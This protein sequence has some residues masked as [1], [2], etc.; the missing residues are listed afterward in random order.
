MNPGLR[1]NL[2]LIRILLGLVTGILLWLIW[3][4][5]AIT[6]PEIESIKF[7]YF[8]TE[9]LFS[10]LAHSSQAA[11]SPYTIITNWRGL[12]PLACLF[13]VLF[14]TLNPL[15]R[16][17][18]WI[19]SL[20]LAGVTAFSCFYAFQY[21]VP[22]GGPVIVLNCFYLCGTLIYLETE[23]IERN[24]NLAIDLQQQAE[25][26]RK[27][28][29]KDLHDESLQS[30]SRVIRLA[31]KLHDEL[32]ENPV[33]QEM[34]SRLESCISGM[35]SIISDLHPAQLEEFGLAAALEQLLEE[36]SLASQVKTH[37]QD[38][39]AGQRLPAFH[40][41]CIY[42]IAQ[43]AINNI[44]KHAQASQVNVRLQKTDRQ[45]CLKIGDNG[46]G[47]VRKKKDSFGLQNITYR[48]RLINGKV[49][50]K[51]PDEFPSGTMLV[52]TVPLLKPKP[53]SDTKT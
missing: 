38:T 26:E 25:A 39:S 11:A 32:P 7:R 2:S 28:I 16:F 53:E 22:W 23:K 8:L 21:I 14:S 44:E 19:L 40:E 20:V 4:A 46:N 9:R 36:F 52:L 13:G 47:A 3:Q 24:R 15:S 33:P 51:L 27:R 48:T 29:A 37:F 34:R 17:V 43:E 18:T 49:E 41:L 50:W 12:L 31:D 45:L 10:G 5:S 30:L 35:R 42:R 6:S 1:L